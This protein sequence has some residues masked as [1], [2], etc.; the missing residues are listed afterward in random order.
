MTASVLMAKAHAAMACMVQDRSRSLNGVSFFDQVNMKGGCMQLLRFIAGVAIVLLPAS[1]CVFALAQTTP[2]PAATSHIAAQTVIRTDSN[3]VLVDVVVSEG[4]GPVRGIDRSHFHVLDDGNEQTISAFDEH[5]PASAN[6][7]AAVR[8][9]PALPPE[10]Y[11]NVP[12]Y[13]EAPAFNV[14]LLDGLNTPMENQMDVRRRMIGFM[15][16][17]PPGTSLAVFTLSSRLRMVQQFTTS[18]ADLAK[19]LRSDKA[20]PQQSVVLDP[21][22]NQGLDS[23]LG[24]MAN[25]SGGMG[26]SSV[27]GVSAI[28]SL[29]QFEADVTAFQTDQRVR[30]T[31]EAMQQLAR[32]LSGIPGRKNVIWFSGSFP[33]A[34]D[35]DSTQQNP[36]EA[37]R[38]YS[39]EIRDTAELL[40]AA[41][42]AMYP[43]DARGLMTPPSFSASYSPSTNLMGAT[44]SRGRGGRARSVSNKPSP[45][46]ND[47]KAQQQLM[48]EQ[49]SM[50]QISEETGG[51][52]YISTNGLEGAIA[53]AIQ[54][55]SNY[56]TI[57]YVP[58]NGALDGKF[59]KIQI[60]VDGRDVKLAYRRGYYADAPERASAHNPGEAS[61]MAAATLHGAPPATQILFETRVLPAGD[62]AFKD[63]KL[64]NGTGGEMR[65]QLRGPLERMI[66][67][68]KVD[69]HTLF[70]TS[71][72]DG[73]VHANLEFTLVAYDGD[74]RRINYLD[75][76]FQVKLR[77]ERV[78]QVMAG[79]VRLHL[80]F[81]LP[82][83]QYSVRI[84]VHDL[85]GGRAESLEVPVAVAKPTP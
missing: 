13:P 4:G 71:T 55:G 1:S 10:T 57:G 45:G 74:G 37:M 19:V 30:M 53:A 58:P 25:L 68:L 77:P 72:S 3:L 85:D 18:A 44:T 56:Y 60:K 64:P 27:A 47:A 6:G 2:V 31:L 35:P 46:S 20:T 63:V 12:I 26:T 69:P 11:T 42:V 81:D 14:L 84:A 51:Q 5:R 70:T 33:I 40:A 62:P 7:I 41:R 83:G 52:E 48:A 34:L 43:V 24:D 32:Y 82:A 49:A 79:G 80:P 78:A 15:G 9:Q 23:M 66:V 50:K 59:H 65:A 61:L 67:D 22:S 76:G 75:S 8:K 38:N 29:S 54:N 21:Q 36:F 16:K 17:I 28:S 73:G 39:D